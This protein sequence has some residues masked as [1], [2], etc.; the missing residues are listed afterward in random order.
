MKTKKLKKVEDGKF[1]DR[2]VTVFALLMIRLMSLLQSVIFL[3]ILVI[4]FI[5][6]LCSNKQCTI[7]WKSLNK[8]VI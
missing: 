1:K 7:Y 6:M 3:I 5:P 4:M 2:L 8:N